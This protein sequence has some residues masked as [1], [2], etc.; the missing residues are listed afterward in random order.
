MLVEAEQALCLIICTRSQNI[1][2]KHLYQS[3][4]KSIDDIAFVFQELLEIAQGF[5][6]YD[7]F[8]EA[9]E[10]W[11]TILSFARHQKRVCDGVSRSPAPLKA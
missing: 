1:D 7:K 10:I 11:K 9:S 5:C 4:D 6:K 8:L 3:L 2:R